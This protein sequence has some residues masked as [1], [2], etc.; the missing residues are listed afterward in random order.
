MTVSADVA[1]AEDV[2]IILK[3]VAPNGASVVLSENNGGTGAN[4]GFACSPLSETIFDDDATV[5]ITQGTPPY[6]GSFQPQEPLALY[7]L[8][9]GTNLNGVW[10]LN[11]VDSVPG[12]T[13][14]LNCWSLTITPEVC[15][16]GGGPCP[17]ADLSL[18]MNAV[19]NAALVGGDLVYNLM[20]SNA[21]PS[22]A[23]N[24][25]IAQTLPLGDVFLTT[26]NFPNA[27]V[28]QLGQTLNLNLGSLPVYGSGHSFCGDHAENSRY[29]NQRCHSR[30][31]D[32]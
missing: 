22:T 23:D 28:S 30:V 3:L 15:T 6:V 1:A 5:P 19:P 2:G 31:G 26:S 16:D 11:V 4:Y 24:I 32:D 7:D 9:N 27:T 17:G 12:N 14:Q 25:S 8:F 18:T 13:A 20:V 29:R 10:T 21:G